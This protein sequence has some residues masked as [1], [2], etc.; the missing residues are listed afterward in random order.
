MK[1]KMSLVF[2]NENKI[3]YLPIELPSLLWIAE[4]IQKRSMVLWIRDLMDRWQL[5]WIF[6]FRKLKVFTV[7]LN[8]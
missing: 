4:N 3:K 8:I 7:Y 2:H 6:L 5:V 1:L